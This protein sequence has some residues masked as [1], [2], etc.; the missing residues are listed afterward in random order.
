MAE[1]PSCVICGRPTYDPAKREPP[2]ARGVRA[3]R[4]VLVCPVCQRERPDWQ[5]TV[6]R[7]VS[8]GGTRLSVTLGEVICRSCGHAS[9]AA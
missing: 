4:Q 3:G 7:C 1:A 6:D 8:C 5:T 2:W 9:P